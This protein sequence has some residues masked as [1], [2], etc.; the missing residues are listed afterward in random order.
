VGGSCFGIL[1]EEKRGEKSKRP[2]CG[3]V[4]WFET[5]FFT[6]GE[7]HELAD[8]TDSEKNLN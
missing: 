8:E 2:K 4:Y 1:L 5:K 7:E 3:L 6:V